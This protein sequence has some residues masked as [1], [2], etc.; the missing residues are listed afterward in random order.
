MTIFHFCYSLFLGAPPHRVHL[1]PSGVPPSSRQVGVPNQSYGS[2]TH[3]LYV[4]AFFCNID[5]GHVSENA[6]QTEARI[7]CEQSLSKLG[8]TGE[9]KMAERESFPMASCFLLSLDFLARLTILRDCSQS[10]ARTRKKNSF[11]REKKTAQS[12]SLGSADLKG[13][14]SF[15]QSLVFSFSF[16]KTRKEPLLT[17]WCE[18]YRAAGGGT[19]GNSWWGCAARFFKSWPYFRPK[20]CRFPHLFSDKTSKIH[21][22][23]QTWPLG[24]N[25]VIIT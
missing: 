16:K 15:R 10:K 13:L 21:T 18:S 9:S 8:R 24:T 25:Y 17:G 12:R 5:A 14:T 19:P 7:D 20:T 11:T 23:F 6:L 3:F 2:W 1:S 4:N 22:R